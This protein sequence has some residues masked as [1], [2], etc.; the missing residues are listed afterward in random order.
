PMTAADLARDAGVGAGVV[1]GLA[2]IGAAEAAELA[3][4][5]ELPG[6]EPDPDASTVVLSAYQAAAAGTL[7]AAVDARAFSAT[8]LE[9]VTGSGKT[10]VYFEAV[11]AAL[12]AGRQ[13]LVLV[14]EIA[15]TAQW[16]ERFAKRFGTAPALWHSDVRARDRRKVWRGIAEGRVK[17][18]VGARSALFL[19]FPDLGLIVVDEEH[20]NSFKQE[21]GVVYHARDMAVVRAHLGGIP[22]V[23]ASA[24]PALETVANVERGRYRKVELPLRHGGALLPDVRLVDMR[25]HPPPPRRWLSP[26]LESEIGAALAAGE[27]AMLF[28]NRRGYAPVTVCRA[29]GAKLECPNCSAWLVEHRLAGRLQCHHCGYGAPPP[30]MCSAC[31]AENSLV[32][33]GPG[34]ERLAEEATALFPESR[35]AIMASDTLHGPEAAQDFVR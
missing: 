25:R 1:K 22:A 26:A 28:L 17:V 9:G 8:L 11:A 34:V 5:D 10:E 7:T 2:E 31:G 4:E 32:G 19:P 15:L 13:A 29:C 27:Q 16:I 12:R 23:L 20:D 18:V 33:C 30:R 6:T 3:S 14:P 21:D 24:T 35:I